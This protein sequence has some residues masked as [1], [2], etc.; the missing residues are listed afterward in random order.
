MNGYPPK[1]A[2]EITIQPGVDLKCIQMAMASESDSSW[3][4]DDDSSDLDTDSLQAS[5][6]RIRHVNRG[7]TGLADLY[8][9]T[10]TNNDS[11]DSDDSDSDDKRPR[12]TERLH[13][14]RHPR[15]NIQKLQD[16]HTLDMERH[17]LSR[18]FTQKSFNTKATFLKIPLTS[19]TIHQSGNPTQ[20][21]PLHNA[22]SSGHISFTGTIHHENVVH[23]LEDIEIVDVLIDNLGSLGPGDRPAAF[24]CRNSISLATKLSGEYNCHYLLQSPDAKYT[25]I[26]DDFVWLATFTKNV[27]DYVQWSVSNSHSVRLSDF[28]SSFHTKLVDWHSLNMDFK[29][30]CGMAGTTDFRR[31][32]TSCR[33]ACFLYDKIRD[34]NRDDDSILTQPLWK[35]TS[36]QL[37]GSTF[38]YKILLNRPTYVTPLIKEAFSVSFPHWQKRRDTGEDLMVTIKISP[39]VLRWRSERSHSSGLGDKLTHRRPQHFEQHDGY[40]ISMAAMLLEKARKEVPV[41]TPPQELLHKAV[42]VQNNTDFKYAYVYGLCNNNREVMIRWLTLP[43]QTVCE[44]RTAGKVQTRSTTFYPIGNELF[45][46][47]ESCQKVP[48][49]KVISVHDITV[50]QNH[51]TTDNGFFVHSRYSSADHAIY[52]L[53]ADDHSCC[54]ECDVDMSNSQ[55]SST[56]KVFTSKRT[57]AFRGTCQMFSLCSGAGLFDCG[58]MTGAQGLFET[59][60]AVDCDY[61]ALKSFQLNHDNPRCEFHNKDM[62]DLFYEFCEGKRPLPE[63]QLLIAGCP[64]QGFTRLN[65]KR[66][67]DNGTKNCSMLGQT[68]SWVDL[69]RPQMILIENVKDM[70]P[71]GTTKNTGASAAGQCISVLVSMGYSARL[72]TIRASDYGGATSRDRLFIIATVPDIQLPQ[73]PRPT[74]GNGETEAVPI[75]VSEVTLGLGEIDNN[76]TFLNPG[77][78][79]HVPYRFLDTLEHGIVKKIPTVASERLNNLSTVGSRLDTPAEK[80]WYAQRNKHQKSNS[81]RSWSRK[82]PNKPSDTLVTTFQP[83][84][85]KMGRVLHWLEHRMCSFEELRY[86]HGVPDWFIFVGYQKQQ[87]HQT[88]NSV[89]W[90]T[91]M[92]LGKAF[93]EA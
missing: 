50:L 4:D 72:T 70:D 28:R 31:H 87:M 14:N 44:G 30:W 93:A 89:A 68:L 63:I 75:S 7:D 35:D 78:P 13:A 41:P 22:E 57:K 25:G 23:R 11:D 66:G 82:D 56:P 45:Y 67:S 60:F 8:G 79:D 59:T 20:A 88:G 91:A 18:M 26:F 65:S 85:Y 2:L 64:C 33:H 83:E 38:N 46:T 73:I 55:T 62:N 51:A 21:A 43:N 37:L 49:Y 39:Q 92:V 15:A 12:M 1:T 74:H 81:S 24:T 76:T 27:N 16:R 69:L 80:R 5:S 47:D 71:L 61:A 53:A 54:T 52:R 3:K 9:Y 86:F 6:S 77:R 36:P 34:V 58:V 48:V 17:F 29:A 90:I 42:I 40:N 19:F 84:C 10:L 32:I